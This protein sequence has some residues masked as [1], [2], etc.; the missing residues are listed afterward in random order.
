MFSAIITW[1]PIFPSKA[2]DRAE[3]SQDRKNLFKCART[4]T[5]YVLAYL[6]EADAGK[7][8]RTPGTKVIA[9]GFP[10]SSLF[11]IDVFRGMNDQ[12]QQHIVT[13]YDSCSPG[14]M[15]AYSFPRAFS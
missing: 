4:H 2:R 6:Q 11:S 8:C 7:S 15:P 12:P 5:Q 3:V 1:S 9:N 10:M 13:G 14:A